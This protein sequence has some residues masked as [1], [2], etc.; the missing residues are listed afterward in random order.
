[1]TNIV[2]SKSLEEKTFD[3]CINGKYNDDLKIPLILFSPEVKNE[4]DLNKYLKMYDKIV[5]GINYIGKDNLG[6]AKFIFDSLNDSKL[7]RYQFESV[8]FTQVITNQLSGLATDSIGDCRSLT[9]LMST[10][11]QNKGVKNLKILKQKNHLGNIL[12]NKQ[13][14]IEIDNTISNGFGVKT[15]DFYRIEELS[16]VVPSFLNFLGENNRNISEAIQY[17]TKAILLQ[18]EYPEAYINRSIARMKT[19]KFSNTLLAKG[20]LNTALKQGFLEPELYYYLGKVEN[21][22]GNF[23]SGIVNLDKAIECDPNERGVHLERGRAFYQ[24]GKF[25]YALRD[26]EIELSKGLGNHKIY[27]YLALANFKLGNKKEAKENFKIYKEF[28]DF[29]KNS[30]ENSVLEQDKK[31]NNSFELNVE[32]GEEFCLYG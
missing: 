20:D 3:E 30:K 22:L 8:P 25:D 1:M 28:E 12:K 23:S 31:F 10:V 15:K 18:N 26:F 6:K 24:I 29:L 13:D 27:H 16:F 2:K 19:E 4:K 7:N 17:Y 11:S 5:S 9:Y 32:N 14:L 21:N